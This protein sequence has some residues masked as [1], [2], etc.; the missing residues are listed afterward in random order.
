MEN[1][2]DGTSTDPTRYAGSARQM[3]VR[4]RRPDD[5][6]AC[7]EALAGVHAADAYPL[8]WPADPPTWLT[9]DTLLSAWVAAD[10][11]RVLGHVALCSAAGDAAAPLWSAA[12]GLPPEQIA[13]IARL[14]VAPSARD[15]GLGAALL[16][17]AC[18]EARLRGM[19]P[20]LEVLDH[21]RAAIALY[22]RLGWQRVASVPTRW[23]G[24]DEGHALLHHYVA[25]D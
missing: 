9:P 16:A 19:R 6:G 21:D 18:A 1:R 7:V 13:V 3:I 15:R 2:M 11:P 17:A 20:A 12:S 25:P 10:G 22:E 5:M 8:Y 14:F 4:V 23:T 24:A